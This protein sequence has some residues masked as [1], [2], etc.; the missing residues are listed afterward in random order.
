MEALDNLIIK[1][2]RLPGVGIKSA[3]RLAF[4][5]L[6]MSDEDAQALADAILAAEKQ[7]PAVNSREFLTENADRRI[8]VGKYIEIFEKVTR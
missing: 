7:R 3:Q 2:N 1:L 4:H 5:I 8:S 6:S